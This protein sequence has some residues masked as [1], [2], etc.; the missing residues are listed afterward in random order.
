MWVKI[1]ASFI[2]HNAADEMQFEYEFHMN[3][4]I[5]LYSKLAP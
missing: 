1:L 5:H 4:H 2:V 3:F